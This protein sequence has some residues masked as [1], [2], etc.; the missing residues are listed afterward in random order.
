MSENDQEL[1]DMVAAV[2]QRFKVIAGLHPGKKKNNPP[3]LE[4]ATGI[5]HCSLLD[6]T[7][8]LLVNGCFGLFP[9][10]SEKDN[11][12]GLDDLKMLRLG[13]KS[14]HF[15]RLKVVQDFFG[16]WTSGKLISKPGAS[17]NVSWPNDDLIRTRKNLKITAFRMIRGLPDLH[18]SKKFAPGP[19]DEEPVKG[20]LGKKSSDYFSSISINVSLSVLSLMS[21]F[22]AVQ[23]SIDKALLPCYL[24]QPKINNRLTRANKIYNEEIASRPVEGREEFSMLET[25]WGKSDKGFD[26]ESYTVTFYQVGEGVKESCAHILPSMNSEFFAEFDGLVGNPVGYKPTE[27]NAKRLFVCIT[28]HTWDDFL[29]KEEKTTYDEWEEQDK[30]M[31]ICA[32]VLLYIHYVYYGLNSQEQ[33]DYLLMDL[34]SILCQKVDY[35]FPRSGGKLGPDNSGKDVALMQFNDLTLHGPTAACTRHKCML[36]MNAINCLRSGHLDGGGR[37]GGLMY[38]LLE[39]YPENI[40]GLALSDRSMEG[41]EFSLKLHSGIPPDFQTLSK[42]CI[43][44]LVQANVKTDMNEMT[45]DDL[46]LNSEYSDYIQ[47]ELSGAERQSAVD[48]ITNILQ[49]CIDER[50]DISDYMQPGELKWRKDTTKAKDKILKKEDAK[51]NQT[52]LQNFWKQITIKLDQ[53]KSDSIRDLFAVAKKS[54]FLETKSAPTQTDLQMSAGDPENGISSERFAE[55]VIDYFQ[56]R[57]ITG[58]YDRSGITT[59]RPDING[60]VFLISNFVCNK[61]SCSDLLSLLANEGAGSV[62]TANKDD[63]PKDLFFSFEAESS[64]SLVAPGLPGDGGLTYRVS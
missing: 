8:F 9:F 62:I 59:T 17:Y 45:R 2:K 10:I 46:F 26:P 20:S 3:E 25:A 30:A 51:K 15:M 32:K 24:S 40:R 60:L 16:L 12:P 34:S 1:P 52:Q 41:N 38:G 64:G 55:R 7:V 63:L 48:A 58:P 44:R 18:G 61:S 11:N 4:N 49:Q 35:N 21:N 22:G 31:V 29:T 37:L 14:N 33:W 53:E 43:I 54:I 27:E 5:G 19:D 56:E 39:R 6:T 42:P 23:S 47:K 36:F 13:R 28:G 57:R 50:S